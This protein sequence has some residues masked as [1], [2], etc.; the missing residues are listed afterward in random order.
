MEVLEVLAAQ[1]TT[2]CIVELGIQQFVF[3]GDLEVVCKALTDVDFFHS[4]IGHIIKDVVFTISSLRTHASSHTRWQG[5][6]ITHAL[7]KRVRL[8]FVLLVWMKHVLP[9]ILNLF[10]FYF[11][12]T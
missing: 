12:A 9:G 1:R 2:L 3:E 8:S 5:N 10:F 6:S 4:A 11:L 7:D